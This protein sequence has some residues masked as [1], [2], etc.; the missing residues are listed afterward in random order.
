M[1]FQPISFAVIFSL[2]PIIAFTLFEGC[3]KD[4]T[5]L[6]VNAPLGFDFPTYTPTP[7]KGA[8]NIYV[9]DTIPRQGVTVV[10]YDTTFSNPVTNVTDQFGNAPFNPSNLQIGTYTAVVLAQGRYG[11]SSQGI[12]LTSLPNGPVSCS[13]IAASQSLTINSG[14]PASYTTSSGTSAFNFGVSYIQPGTLD[15]PVSISTNALDSAWT[16]TPS[17][18]VLSMSNPSTI[19]SID[20]NSC[21]VLNEPVTW[22][23]LDFLGSP[24]GVVGTVINKTFG[25]NVQVSVSTTFSTC[26]CFGGNCHDTMTSTLTLNSPNDCNTVWSVQINSLAP[27]NM[28]NGQ[29]YTSGNSN[30]TPCGGGA[31]TWNVRISSPL[32]SASGSGGSGTIINKTF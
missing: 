23:A 32:G 2:L 3:K 19:A 28:T 7:V 5:P 14:I 17:A 1:K 18:F 24:V 12:T 30:H 4:S 27:R 13:F 10:L 16:S 9:Y 8:F 31:P 29:T 11:Y 26:Q 25:V 22:T 15:V 20:R 21:S 6:G